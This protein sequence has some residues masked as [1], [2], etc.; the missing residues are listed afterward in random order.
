MGPDDQ[1]DVTCP[2][3]KDKG[4]TRNEMS[5]WELTLHPVLSTNLIASS[6]FLG[7]IYINSFFWAQGEFVLMIWLNPY[8]CQYFW[9]LGHRRGN[10]R[11]RKQTLFIHIS[12]FKG[13]N[14]ISKSCQWLSKIR[15]LSAYRISERK[16]QSRLSWTR[17]SWAR[18]ASWL[19]LA[20]RHLETRQS[21]KGREI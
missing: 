12:S 13:Y 19:H 20:G 6:G 9:P 5:A 16:S 10:S 15:S 11:Y 8:G 14:A 18:S 2:W 17:A 3:S 21:R 7:K 1:K 4:E